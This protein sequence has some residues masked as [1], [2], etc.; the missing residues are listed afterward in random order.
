[1]NVYKFIPT[2]HYSGNIIIAAHNALEAVKII[3]SNSFLESIYVHDN[4]NWKK[5]DGLEY[6]KEPGILLWHIVDS[7]DFCRH[8]YCNYASI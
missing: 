1:M 2:K 5:I 8:K 4:C 3:S 7:R 6:N